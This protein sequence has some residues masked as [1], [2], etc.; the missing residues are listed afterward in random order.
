VPVLVNGSKV[1]AESEAIARYVD[2]LPGGPSLIPGSAKSAVDKFLKLANDVST[3]DLVSC[4]ALKAPHSLAKAVLPSLAEGTLAKLKALQAD[5]DTPEA[6]KKLLNSKI[7]AVN[8]KLAKYSEPAVHFDKAKTAFIVLLDSAEKALG[9]CAPVPEGEAPKPCYLAGGDAPSLADLVLVSLLARANWYAE[10]KELFTSRP[11]LAAFW[12]HMAARPAFEA[13]DVWS[14]LKPIAGLMMLGEAAADAASF[15]WA[16]AAHEWK[17]S[18]A[19]G[20]GKAWHSVADPVAG[21]A[22]ATG[23]AIDKHVISPITESTQW[24]AGMLVIN[25]QVMPKIRDATHS[26]GDFINERVVTPVKAGGEYASAKLSE[27]ACATAA[28]AKHA[29]E[30]TAEAAKHAAE[31]T[32]EAAKHAAEA[33]KAAAE[34]AKSGLSPKSGEEVAAPPAAAAA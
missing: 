26:A 16:A 30:A 7:E 15:C 13:A 6:T 22:R 25:T 24:K 9:P 14:G 3:E 34:R 8:A 29:A 19:P 1:V 33:T 18:V 28:A 4:S 27:A 21:A 20:A 12:A 5:A 10:P 23:D 31:A 11:P 17:E 32:A 2:T